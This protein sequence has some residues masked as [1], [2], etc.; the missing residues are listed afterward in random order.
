MDEMMTVVD[1][2]CPFCGKEYTITV[3]VKGFQEWKNGISIQ[4]AMPELS[5][6]DRESLISGI[7]LECWEKTFG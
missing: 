6:E 5:A 3:P 1:V 7:C 4:R 2:V